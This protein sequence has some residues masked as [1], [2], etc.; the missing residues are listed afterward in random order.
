MADT[1]TTNLNLTKPEVGA[2]TD[3]W[4]TK[5]NDDLDDLDALFSSTGTSVAMNLDGAVIDSSVIGGTTPAAGTFTTLTAN[6]SITG[7][8][9]TAAQPNITSVGTLSSLTVSGDL[10]VDTNTLYVDSTNNYVG[11]GTTSP[12]S[13]LEL[14]ATEA[15][16]FDGTATDGQA[17]NGSTLAIQNLSDTDNTFTQLLFRN[18]NTSKA[19]A[20]IASLTDSTGT[21]MAFVVENNGSPNE[22]LRIDKT[23]QVGIGTASPT[24][25]LTIKATDPRISLEDSNSVATGANGLIEFDGTDTRLGYMGAVSGDLH[26]FTDSGTNG[27]IIFSTN[28][29]EAARIDSSGNVGIGTTSPA[30]HLH[31]ASSGTE[32]ATIRLDAPSNTTPATYLLRAHDGD[33]DIRNS[34]TSTTALTIDSSGNVGIGTSSPPHKFSVFGTGAGNATVQ[35]EGEGGADPYINFL[36]NNTQHWSVGIDDSDGDKFKISEHSGL[37]T[38]DYLV[39]DTSGNV[40]I[41]G[42]TTTATSLNNLSIGAYADASSGIVLRAT[43]AS[44]L[45][46]EDNSSVTAARVYY[47]HASGYMAFNTE[48]TERMRID[49]SG[50]VG[51]GMTN[52]AYVLDVT[53][54]TGNAYISV[55]R[56]T[57]SQGEVGYKLGGGTGGGQWYIYQPT[58]SNDLRF[59]QGSDKVT[60]DTSGNLLVGRTT[61]EGNTQG[62]ALQSNAQSKYCAT[63]QNDGNDNGRLGIQIFAGTDNN[64]GTNTHINFG[65]GDGDGVGSITSSGGTVSY[66]AFTASHFVSLPNA[67]KESGYDY[68]TLVEITGV[69]YANPKHPRSIRYNVQK[70]QSSNSKKVLGAY[71]GNLS[72]SVHADTEGDYANNLH[73]VHVLGDGHILC[74]NEGGNISVGDG[75]C[76]SSVAGIGMKATESPSMII[77]IAQEDVT[78]D[79]S[80]T[81]LVVVQYGLQQFTPWS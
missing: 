20:R 3:T 4:G 27:E 25:E 35:I 72:Q 33:F 57:Q 11:V 26:M 79:G 67:E 59:Y 68:G 36:A 63:F 9:A 81:K 69:Y 16:T 31:I 30:N 44:A 34:L 74:N 60:F 8:L 17:A 15:T 14:E 29:S 41:G 2:S 76:T 53:D 73:E 5:L 6:T 50:N 38:N 21:E 46:F 52:P 66:N 71:S 10:T 77:G 45:N 47:N 48:Q 23:G 80:E 43:T 39:V 22:V 32:F 58:S 51:I 56:G 1:F 13:L 64:S 7:T 40:G 12:G 55:N 18:R 62:L 78:F 42:D 24:E 75:I 28:N 37:G 49:S 70:S 61:A 65:D 19:V 54:T